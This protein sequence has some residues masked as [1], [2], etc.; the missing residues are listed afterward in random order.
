VRYGFARDFYVILGAFDRQGE[1]AQ[2][3]AQIHPMV[4]WIWLGGLVVLMGGGLALWPAG[5]RA[6]AT[7]RAPAG[8]AIAGG[9][10]EPP[11]D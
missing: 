5:R 10:P 7:V 8:A 6:P 2:I 4:A 9:G 3:K 1:W 11:R